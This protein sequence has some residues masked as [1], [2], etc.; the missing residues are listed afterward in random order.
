MT[1]VEQIM[2]KVKVGLPFLTKYNTM[3]DAEIKAS[4]KVIFDTYHKD[5]DTSLLFGEHS[6]TTRKIV[7]MEIEE[8]CIGYYD[9]ITINVFG[10]A[11]C[12]EH[13]SSRKIVEFNEHFKP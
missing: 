13:G 11:Y 5:I 1:S 3:T 9:S 7:N 2:E 8:I 6:Q 4:L 12:A 10:I